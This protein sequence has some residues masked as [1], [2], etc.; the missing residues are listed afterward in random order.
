MTISIIIYPEGNFK[1][2]L[3]ISLENFVE[4]KN[5]AGRY[6]MNRKK[7]SP[8]RRKSAA[9][10]EICSVGERAA[11]DSLQPF[12]RKALTNGAKGGI[13]ERKWL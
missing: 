8:Y 9:G 1:G 11:A 4:T 3:K 5:A 13:M 2:V 7:F 12:C 10:A 6:A